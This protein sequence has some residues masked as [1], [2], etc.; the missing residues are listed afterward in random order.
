MTDAAGE[1]NAAANAVGRCFL[2]VI[3]HAKLDLMMT[4]N[5]ISEKFLEYF[6]RQGHTRVR[7][8]P[9]LPANDATLLFTYARIK[10]CKAGLLGLVNREYV[11]ACSR[12]KCLRAGGK[13]NDRD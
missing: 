3:T 8:R 6:E 9:L 2:A 10:Q 5:E 4:G 12:Q 13:H 1:S 11:R 7:S